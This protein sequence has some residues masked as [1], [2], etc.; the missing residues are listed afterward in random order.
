MPRLERTITDTVRELMAALPEVEEVVAHGAPTLRVRGKI[1]AAYTINHHGDGRVALNLVA[2]P[3]AQAVFVKMRPRVYFV[4]P[5]VGPRGWL[6]VELD[7]GLGWTTVR[8]HVVEAYEKV[9]PAE[10]V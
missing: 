7:K 10:L 5:Y 4:P 3:G 9:A 1:F 8:E 2:P 6:G